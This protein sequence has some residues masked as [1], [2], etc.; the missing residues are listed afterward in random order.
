V[1]RDG[2]AGPDGVRAIAGLG[3]LAA[4]L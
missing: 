2:G 4:V 1:R 3:E